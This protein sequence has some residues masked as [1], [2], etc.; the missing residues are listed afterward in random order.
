M[1]KWVL[2]FL[3]LTTW[4]PLLRAQGTDNDLETDWRGRAS[5]E[6]DMK[7]FKGFH[8]FTEEQVRIIDNFGRPGRYQMTLGTS[9]KLQPWLK[10][11][12]SYSFMERVNAKKEYSPRHRVSLD[13]TA[14]RKEGPWQFSLKERLQ[15]N[16][17]P[18]SMNEYEQTRNALYLKSRVKTAYKI[19]KIWTPYLFLELKNTLNAPSINADFNTTTQQY[20]TPSGLSAGEQGWFLSGYHDI[21]ICRYR[22][23]LGTEYKFSKAH[24]MDLYLLT[25][26]CRDKNIDANSAGTVLKSMTWDQAMQLTFGV[27]Y[28]Y[29]F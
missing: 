21:Y 25:D 17:R 3:A 5:V 8:M 14:S 2:L 20:L 13:L 19:N 27:G 10:G 1:K 6:L 29:S 15:L 4:L 16:H 9:Y 12:L 11:A 24:A 18:G 28:I 23:G 22:A 26:Y 7:I